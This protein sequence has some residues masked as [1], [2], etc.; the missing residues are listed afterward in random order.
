MFALI[1][2]PRCHLHC[3]AVA[4]AFQ[5][6]SSCS[7]KCNSSLAAKYQHSLKSNPFST[8]MAQEYHVFIEASVRGYHAYFKDATVFIGGV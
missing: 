7:S 4:T 8:L 6:V 2:N 1:T 3:H 5:L